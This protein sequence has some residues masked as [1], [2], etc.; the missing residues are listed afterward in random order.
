M[1]LLIT[2]VLAG[3]AAAA[4]ADSARCVNLSILMTKENP[5]NLTSAMT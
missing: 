3:S 5:T 1:K 2:A 4:T